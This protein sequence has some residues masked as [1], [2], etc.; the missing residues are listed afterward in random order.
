MYNG[1]NYYLNKNP[2]IK[3]DTNETID[4][5]KNIIIDNGICVNLNDKNILNSISNS[6]CKRII[7]EYSS[8]PSNHQEDN[9]LS[10]FLH[11]NSNEID[12]NKIH[13]KRNKRN[14]FNLS[15]LNAP[16]LYNN[17][18]FMKFSCGNDYDCLHLNN[19]IAT[20]TIN[21]SSSNSILSF[22]CIHQISRI[23]RQLTKVTI[24]KHDSSFSSKNS[25]RSVTKLVKDKDK[26][27]SEE[28]GYI[29]VY[30]EGIPTDIVAHS[31]MQLGNYDINKVEY[32][33]DKDNLLEE[34]NENDIKNNN[35]INK[36]FKSSINFITNKIYSF[37]LSLPGK[38]N[39]L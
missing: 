37:I 30:Y 6:C 19:K 23:N 10:C 31:V 5:N 15:C 4:D 38:N 13:N 39:I 8:D 11:S 36:L 18:N 14:N 33:N 16:N 7:P 32:T 25:R 1:K 29:N 12:N 27:L 24:K 26:H 9:Y 3:I 2:V 22:Q 21:N 34:I 35:N 20:N 17:Y 28:N